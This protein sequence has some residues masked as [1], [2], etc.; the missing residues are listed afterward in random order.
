MQGL[1]LAEIARWYHAGADDD[2]LPRL[3]AVVAL[4]LEGAAAR[5]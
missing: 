5:P 3:G 4:Y 1:V 2:L